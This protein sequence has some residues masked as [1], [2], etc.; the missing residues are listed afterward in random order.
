MIT[1]GEL[2]NSALLLETQK[3]KKENLQMAKVVESV[4]LGLVVPNGLDDKG[5]QK[6]RSILIRQIDPA[7]TDEAI[8]AL[9]AAIDQVL[10]EAS[11]RNVVTTK[12]EVY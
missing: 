9:A 12:E 8:T 5:M 10:T 7:F 4:Q 1:A 6:F 2:R 3:Q 11:V